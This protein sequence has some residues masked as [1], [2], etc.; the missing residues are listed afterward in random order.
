VKGVLEGVH[1]LIF[2]LL[3]NFFLIEM[4]WYSFVSF[5]YIFIIILAIVSLNEIDKSSCD[6]GKINKKFIKEWFIFY[7]IYRIIIFFMIIIFFYYFPQSFNMI[8]NLLYISTFI[9]IIM[10]IMEIR[11]LL[12]L[13]YLRN[14]C[15]CAYKNKEKILFWFY[16][17]Y[18]SLFFIGFFIF[19][20]FLLKTFFL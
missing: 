5:I 13:N 19:L 16:L 17:L 18:L 6:C 3:F 14:S 2:G 4:S 9:D 1:I 10:I 12:Y 20:L 15:E 7:L 8:L 11:L